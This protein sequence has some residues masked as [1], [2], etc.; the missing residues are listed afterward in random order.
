MVQA[1]PG[2]ATANVT[3]AALTTILAIVSTVA[4]FIYHDGTR[5][6]IIADPSGEERNP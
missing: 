5:S 1:E 2:L 6:L 4:A 3:A